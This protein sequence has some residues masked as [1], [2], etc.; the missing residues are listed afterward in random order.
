MAGNLL[1]F[2]VIVS[3]ILDIKLFLLA[4]IVVAQLARAL[5]D[6]DLFCP[7]GHSFLLASFRT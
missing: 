7:Y 3:R 5:L 6:C 1:V 4:H 2:L